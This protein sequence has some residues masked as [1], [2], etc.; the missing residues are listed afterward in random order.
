MTTLHEL[1]CVTAINEMFRKGHFSI[2]TIDALITMLGV[3]PD[4][5]AYEILRVLHCV[6]FKSMPRELQQEI[7]RLIRACL[8]D[9]ITLMFEVEQQ[10]VAQQTSQPK[11]DA[12]ALLGFL[13][14]WSGKNGE[15]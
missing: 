14:V 3:I 5:K 11:R 8:A 12:R 6:D 4:R 9:G 2:C 10:Q 15:Q 7:P 13:S 1:T